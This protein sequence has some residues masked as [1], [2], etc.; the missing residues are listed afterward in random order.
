MEVLKGFK[1]K[2][3]KYSQGNSSEKLVNYLFNREV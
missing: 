2:W 3:N 1:L